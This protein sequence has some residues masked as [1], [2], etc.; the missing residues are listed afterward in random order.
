MRRS[1]LAIS[2]LGLAIA[3]AAQPSPFMLASA[4]AGLEGARPERR[5]VLVP[6]EAEAKP[7]WATVVNAGS[8]RISWM[9]DGG[10]GVL[11]L[12]CCK[13][14]FGVQRKVSVDLRAYPVLTWRWRADVLPALGDGRIAK[15]DDEAA[16]VYVAFSPSRA[17]GYIWDS[18]APAGLAFDSPLQLP[19]MRLRIFVLRSGTGEQGRWIDERRDLREDYERAFGESLPKVEAVGIRLWINSQHTGG[20]AAS[21]FSGLAF[22]RAY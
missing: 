7:A 13:A 20:E 3:A 8:P 17:I 21:A 16:Q 1:S 10:A 19:F 6:L 22:E 11:T 9:R 15:S 18:R 4:D 12:C 2:I 14:S 5:R